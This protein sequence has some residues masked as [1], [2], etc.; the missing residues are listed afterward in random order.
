MV[1]STWIHSLYRP[2]RDVERHAEP[3]RHLDDAGHRRWLDPEV[4][5][6]PLDLAASL[7]LAAGL[8]D[9][10]RDLDRERPALQL[11]RAPDAQAVATRLDRLPGDGRRCEHD[12]GVPLDVQHL[13]APHPGLDLRDVARRLRAGHDG[14]LARLEAQAD[15]RACRV[16][17]GHHDSTLGDRRVDL[18]V[19]A[20]EL[21]Q[22]RAAEV[23]PDTARGRI[24]REGLRPIGPEA[25]RAR[26]QGRHCDRRDPFH[27]TAGYAARDRAR[28]PCERFVTSKM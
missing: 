1:A 15:G 12:L 14:Q 19:V 4:A 27:R 16:A 24:D 23:D 3:V 13:G 2:G 10:E 7:D 5:Q 8:A 22:A 25:D 6:A 17:I 21:E 11:E 18:V 28:N 26:E 9:L 20:E